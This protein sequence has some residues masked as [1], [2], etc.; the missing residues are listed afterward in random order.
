MIR[1]LILRWSQNTRYH[2]Y[3]GIFGEMY[4]T[5]LAAVALC[6]LIGTDYRESMCILF[7]LQCL[8]WRHFFR[9]TMRVVGVA[10]LITFSCML[11]AS[12]FEKYAFVWTWE[13]WGYLVIALIIQGY[14]LVRVARAHALS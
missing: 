4:A 5:I 14:V 3:V 8:V 9:D 1:S 7:L 12:G 11:L 2:P 10:A 6:V 13:N